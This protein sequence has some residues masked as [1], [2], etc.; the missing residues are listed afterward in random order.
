MNYEDSDETRASVQPFIE[1]PKYIHIV[2]PKTVIWYHSS[3]KT[4]DSP[5]SAK[6]RIVELRQ[7]GLSPVSVN[8]HLRCVSILALTGQGLE[9]W[10]AKRGAEDP[11]DLHQSTGEGADLVQA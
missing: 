3:L 8:V 6:T 1:E 7:R 10:Q 9:D 2:S 4:L 5:E 11:C